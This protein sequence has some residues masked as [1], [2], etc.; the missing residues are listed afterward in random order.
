MSG[1]FIELTEIQEYARQIASRFDPEKI[2]LFGSHA[3]GNP[4]AESDVD[5]LVLMEFEGLPQ[6]QAYRIRMEL[7]RRFPLDLIV[8]RPREVERR[9]QMGDFFLREALEKGRVIHERTGT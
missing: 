3:R 6:D 1:K 9:V 2:V 7:P 4:D 5:L 8:R